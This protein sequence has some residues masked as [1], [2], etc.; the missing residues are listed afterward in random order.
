MKIRIQT[1]TYRILFVIWTAIMFTMTSI[2]ELNTAP[3][4]LLNIDKLYHIILYFVFTV[5]YIRMNKDKQ[6]RGTLRVLIILLLILPFLDELHQIPI[7]GRSFSLLDVIADVI[8]FFAAIILFRKE[9]L[10][11]QH[12]P[13]EG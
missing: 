1:K 4:R 3:D 8:G 12:L 9:L 11:K 5:L 2:P 10:Q 13:R 6:G 7:P